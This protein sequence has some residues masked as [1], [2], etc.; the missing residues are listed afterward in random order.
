MVSCEALYPVRG[1]AKSHLALRSAA[2][3]FLERLSISG[4]C[5]P[6]G[7]LTRPSGLPDRIEVPGR[8]RNAGRL[9][10]QRRSVGNARLLGYSGNRLVSGC[11]LGNRAFSQS[12]CCP[13]MLSETA[14]VC[15]CVASAEQCTPT[16]S[17]PVLQFGCD[18][19]NFWAYFVLRLQLPIVVSVRER[20]SQSPVSGPRL[21]GMPIRSA[22]RI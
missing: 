18:Q 20:E 9:A 17:L 2:R 21:P 1:L 4:K 19:L 13:A 12:N 5:V 10:N 15:C 8:S 11:V 14:V 22:L 16:L 3:L 7:I 6:S